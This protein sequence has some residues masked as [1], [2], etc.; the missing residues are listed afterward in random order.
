MKAKPIGLPTAWFH[1]YKVEKHMKLNNIFIRNINKW[2]KERHR[3]EYKIIV[4]LPQGEGW[5]LGEWAWGRAYRGALNIHVK[6]FFRISLLTWLV[7]N[8]WV[9]GVRT[10][11]AFLWISCLGVFGK[12]VRTRW[13]LLWLHCINISYINTDAHTLLI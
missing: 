4:Y 2:G 5:K 6:F 13:R 9:H 3:N 10:L 7:S 11:M 1:L 8:N 12:T